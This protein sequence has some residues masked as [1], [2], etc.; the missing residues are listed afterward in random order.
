MPQA[1]IQ[2]LPTL[3]GVRR[4]VFVIPE[5]DVIIQWPSKMS[6]DSFQDLNDHLKI[7]LRKLKRTLPPPSSSDQGSDSEDDDDSA[8]GVELDH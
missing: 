2:T 7:F 8:E 6:G 1:P 4:E 3:D 5:G